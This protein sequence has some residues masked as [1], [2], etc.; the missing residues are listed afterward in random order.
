MWGW[1]GE[2]PRTGDG[3]NLETGRRLSLENIRRRSC[4]ITG[5]LR[6]IESM[7]CAARAK[8]K[9][10]TRPAGPSAVWQRSAR[11]LRFGCSG[12]EAV[13]RA[14]S[15]QFRWHRRHVP[16]IVVLDMVGVAIVPLYCYA[17]PID[18]NNGSAIAEA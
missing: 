7:P 15:H 2:K 10:F 11:S 17:A 3:W 9:R 5:A 18:N 16:H 12:F 14:S 13:L 8:M 1:A 4:R 6:P